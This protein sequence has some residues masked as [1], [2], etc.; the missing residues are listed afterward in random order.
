MSTENNGYVAHVF[1]QHH[2]AVEVCFSLEHLRIL[3]G[4]ICETHWGSEGEIV[5]ATIR[6]GGRDWC[7]P[8]HESA[9]GG[10]WESHCEDFYGG[11]GPSDQD[12]F[13]ASRDCG[14]KL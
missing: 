5:P 3:T 4:P 9:V 1:K 2:D 13:E 12:R 10:Q 14:R 7:E 6:D 11:S 8:C